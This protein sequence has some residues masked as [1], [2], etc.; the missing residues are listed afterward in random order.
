MKAV[1]HPT[2]LELVAAVQ[3]LQAPRSLTQTDTVKAR[4]AVLSKVGQFF[5]FL[6]NS[7]TFTIT[8]NLF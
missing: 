2:E 4:I 5:A 8:Q 3:K 6:S 7:Q 1:H